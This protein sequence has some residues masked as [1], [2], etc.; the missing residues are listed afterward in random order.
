MINNLVFERN[1]NVITVMNKR[2]LS[3][4]ATITCSESRA[5]IK[6]AGMRS[7]YCANNPKTAVDIIEI[8]AKAR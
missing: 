6:I 7:V 8:F 1:G 4:F 5:S 2:N 3:R